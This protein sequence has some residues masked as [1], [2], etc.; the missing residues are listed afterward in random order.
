[1]ARAQDGRAR[2]RSIPAHWSSQATMTEGRESAEY[3]RGFGELS[4]EMM[5]AM[6]DQSLD[7]VKILDPTGSVEFLNRAGRCSMEIEDF[8]AIAGRP[9]D[10]MW[11]DESRA[12]VRAAI[13]AAQAGGSD[14]FV[15]LCPTAGGTAKW[16]DVTV[17]PV[18]DAGGRPFALLAISRDV[19]DRQRTLESNETLAHEMRHRLRNAFAVSGAIALASAREEPEHRAFAETLAQRY[20]SLSLAQSKLLDGSDGQTLR[21]LA[22]HIAE[23]FDRDRGLVRA[24]DLPDLTLGEQQS[25][26]VALVLGELCTNSLKHGA[27]R[28]G[29]PVDITASLDDGTLTLAWSEALS[30]DETGPPAD[31]QRGGSGYG[32]MERMARAHSGTFAVTLGAD[33]LDALLTMPTTM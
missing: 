19:S 10:T 18:R 33:R 11:P 3:V 4:R 20:T 32:L 23:G 30:R 27:L 6:L 21:E 24:G 28:A 26:L 9:W 8:C 13:A 5:A 16:W 17:S 7:C 31:R 29:T 14:R 12:R 22:Q 15:A 25:R 2:G 1:M